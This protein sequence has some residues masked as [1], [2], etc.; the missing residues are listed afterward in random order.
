MIFYLFYLRDI[1]KTTS[2][3][4]KELVIEIDGGRRKFMIIVCYA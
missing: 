1:I 2:D 3:T 4:S